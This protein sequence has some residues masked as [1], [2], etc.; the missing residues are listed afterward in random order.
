MNDL[1]K[2]FDKIKN[3]LANIQPNPFCKNYNK[4]SQSK[5]I[6][7]SELDMVA[8]PDMEELNV[9]LI[10]LPSIDLKNHKEIHAT[11][12]NKSIRGFSKEITQRK[13][14]KYSIK[15]GEY[16][17]ECYQTAV[18]YAINELKANIVC[19]NELGLPINKTGNSACKEAIDFS[20]KMA[21]EN[22]CVIIAGSVHDPR[23]HLNTTY[24]FCPRKVMQ[25]YKQVSATTEGEFITV[26]PE[27]ETLT[28]SV[29]GISIS[30]L[31]CLDLADY[32]SVVSAIRG[33]DYSPH[34]LFVPSYSKFY[35]SLE[36]LS[37][38]I[39]GALSG[40][41]ALTNFFHANKPSHFLHMYGSEIPQTTDVTTL[42]PDEKSPEFSVS[43]FKLN[44]RKLDSFKKGQKGLDKSMGWLFGLNEAKL[45]E[46]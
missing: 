21:Q 20:K 39:S 27:R 44:S 31:L 41:V 4:I 22:N 25:Y 8:F 7:L 42:F 26:P 5:Y 30:I 2:P 11:K 17:F 13:L 1:R 9:V 34:L 24:I 12:D 38:T 16:L 29:F 32:S 14:C 36:R 28:I 3:D 35:E 33:Q 46:N 43:L 40:G 37:T 15:F 10:S 18:N 19:I 6:N 23:S 45:F